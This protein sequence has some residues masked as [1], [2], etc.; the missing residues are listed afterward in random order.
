MIKVLH[1]TYLGKRCTNSSMVSNRGDLA[2]KPGQ[3]CFVHTYIRD[4]IRKL[5]STRPSCTYSCIVTTKPVWMQR[6][7]T[8]GVSGMRHHQEVAG[9]V[10]FSQLAYGGFR[11]HDLR[12]RSP[13]YTTYLR[14]TLLLTYDNRQ[15]SKPCSVNK[16]QVIQ[17]MVMQNGILSFE[18]GLSEEKSS[19]SFLRNDFSFIFFSCWY[20]F[21]T[22]ALLMFTAYPPWITCFFLMVQSPHALCFLWLGINV[23]LCQKLRYLSCI[24]GGASVAHFDASLSCSQ[25]TTEECWLIIFHQIRY[26][27][28]AIDNFNVFFYETA[29]KIFLQN[30]ITKKATFCKV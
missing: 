16:T 11:K 28:G 4:A 18:N 26:L 23:V 8:G 7:T 24:R 17:M 9:K 5:K 14:V 13:D 22:I 19:S 30:K 12:C 2:W 20:Y 21:L 6:G 15:N 27:D 29:R 10:L 1:M 25:I 3:V